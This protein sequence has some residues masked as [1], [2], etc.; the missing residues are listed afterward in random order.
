MGRATEFP[1]NVLRRQVRAQAAAPGFCLTPVTGE[2]G[3][4]HPA[5]PPGAGNG[6]WSLRLEYGSQFHPRDW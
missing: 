3:M 4:S 5:T 1:S 6:H 2:P